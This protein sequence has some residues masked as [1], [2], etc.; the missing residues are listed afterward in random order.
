MATVILNQV[1]IFNEARLVFKVELIHIIKL[2]EI[3]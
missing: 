1:I 2:T 3:F